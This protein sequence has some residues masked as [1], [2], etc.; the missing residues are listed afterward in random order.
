[1][2]DNQFEDNHIDTPLVR[3]FVAALRRFEQNSEPADLVE[4]FADGA[5]ATRLDS[6]GDRTDVEA[7]WREYRDQFQ[8]LSTTFVNAVEGSGQCAL[9]WTSKATM[10]DGR[11][12]EYRGVT[13]LDLDGERI[14]RLRTY[15]DSAVFVTTPAG[16]GR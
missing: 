6:R 11:P 14:A 16:V 1:M 15:Y 2:E 4:L 7:F 9:E 10:P 8:D 12:V 5:T 13:V 3:S